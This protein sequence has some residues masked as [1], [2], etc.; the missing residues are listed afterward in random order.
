MGALSGIFGILIAALQA[1]DAI[2]V[3]P[4][5]PKFEVASIKPAPQP[6]GIMWG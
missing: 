5:G 1:G 3:K 2:T 6:P 4:S